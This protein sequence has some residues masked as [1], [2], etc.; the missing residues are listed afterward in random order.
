MGIKHFV[1]RPHVESLF[2]WGTED[3]LAEARLYF[4]RARLGDYYYDRLTLAV[5]GGELVI[6]FSD[7]LWE[8]P[9]T[10]RVPVGHFALYSSRTDMDIYS[11]ATVAERLFPA[12][13]FPGAA[14]PS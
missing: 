4:S 2:E 3:T 1:Y 11:P 5:E 8:E 13:E 14:I 12:E 7:S 10:Y 9:I 6:T